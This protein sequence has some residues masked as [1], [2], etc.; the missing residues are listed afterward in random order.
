MD[1]LAIV[2]K[3]VHRDG[4]WQLLECAPAW[5]GNWTWDAFVAMRW[6]GNRGER[7]VIV[8]NYS[9]HHAQCYLRLP[10]SDLAGISWRFQD[11]MSDAH[12]DRGGS[13]L[14]TNGLFLDMRP[15]QYHVF[16]MKKLKA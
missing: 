10:F 14:V 9:M 5:E 7:T 4:T 2:N 12:Y 11:L 16:E 13:A 3:P 8:A 1:L 15:W 6:L